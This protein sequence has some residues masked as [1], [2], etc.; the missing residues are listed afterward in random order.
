MKKVTAIRAGKGRAKRVNV[1]LDG[2]FAFSLDAGVAA[3]ENLKK[4]QELSDERTEALVREDCFCR[5]LGAAARYLSY[6]PRSE[7]ELLEKLLQR[8]FDR[9]TVESVLAR[10]KEQGLVDD[11][12]FARFWR[13]HRLCFNPRSRWLT[14][15]ELKQKGVSGDVIDQ[16]VQT[17]DDEDAAYR[18]ASS[19][20]RL[21]ARCD[22][23]SFRQ[24]LGGYLRRRGF[25]YNVINRTVDA[26]WQEREE[27]QNN[28]IGE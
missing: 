2:Q 13:D 8:G 10:L 7:S 24:R 21:L 3:K 17:V 18:A 23:Q 5:C 25:G 16:A 9:D 27:P 6:R 22:Y 15:L 20:A 4:E 26:L 12:A 19:K 1:F 11:A 28:S 14:I